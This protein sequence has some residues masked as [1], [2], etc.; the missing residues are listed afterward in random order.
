MAGSKRSRA[1]GSL[2]LALQAML[3]VTLIIIAAS[4]SGDSA[5]KNGG[6]AG[7]TGAAP[8]TGDYRETF[9]TGIIGRY[10]A[11]GALDASLREQSIADCRDNPSGASPTLMGD[12]LQDFAACIAGLSC[13]NLDGA[14]DVCWPAGLKKLG[15]GTLPA[16]VVDECAGGSS[17]TCANLVVSQVSGSDVVSICL[18]KWQMCTTASGFT[19]DDCLSLLAF[20]Q[21]SRDAAGACL[22]LECPAA[23]QCLR[24]HGTV[25]W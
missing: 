25:N 19:E 3:F 17:E 10:V 11:C 15:A 18:R 4:C 13:E 5:V 20:T 1:H 16:A 6:G 2:L 22:G 21:T 9:C 7:G 12:F 23:G 24:E 14:D 8:A